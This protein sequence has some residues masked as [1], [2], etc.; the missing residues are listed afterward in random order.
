MILQAENL[1]VFRQQSAV[2]ENL[3]F[4]VPESSICALLG[5]NGS[6]KSTLISAVLGL[7]EYNGTLNLMGK[8]PRS[9]SGT[10]IARTVALVP[11]DT[12]ASF[13]F[14]VTQ[15]VEMGRLPHRGLFGGMGASG[16]QV[17]DNALDVCELKNL[18]HRDICSLSGGE[19]QRVFIARA[20]V[21]E[22]RFLIMDEPTSNLDV[23]MAVRIME[24]I[25]T[26]NRET[27]T[28][29]LVVFHDLGLA[30]AYCDHAICLK[31]GRAAAQGP[32]SS[33]MNS[34]TLSRVFDTDILVR[35]GNT[36]GMPG[37]AVVPLGSVPLSGDFQGQR[38]HVIPGGGSAGPYMMS[39]RAAGCP[40]TCGPVSEGDADF[41]L[42]RDMG[43]EFITLEPFGSIGERE[44]RIHEE[45]IFRSDIVVLP[46]IPV[47]ERNLSSIS[48]CLEAARSGKRVWYCNHPPFESRNFAGA[49]ACKLF[50]ELSS[51]ATSIPFSGLPGFLSC[52]SPPQSSND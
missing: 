48:L 29:V 38:F 33:V 4:V 34:L 6:G 1:T 9:M 23:S 51:A 21:Q 27:G 52:L 2:L 14:T 22:P 15:V 40:V 8:S 37:F 36:L 49:G 43:L 13:G 20:M 28:T 31:E 32:S 35:E 46:P 11:Q 30:A 7:L 26:L 39:L 3:D 16:R 19:R 42:A 24:V 47:G 17:V 44:C 10:D 50:N 5:P 12:G 41:F 18:R 25:R 45:M